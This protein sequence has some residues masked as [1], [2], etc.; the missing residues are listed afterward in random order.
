MDDRLGSI[1]DCCKVSDRNRDC[2]DFAIDNS[3]VGDS[4]SRAMPK[5]ALCGS[6]DI[7]MI[8][9]GAGE[10]GIGGVVIV[11][12]TVISL[13]IPYN[14]KPRGPFVLYIYIGDTM[15]RGVYIPFSEQNRLAENS[16][17]RGVANCG[18]KEV[19]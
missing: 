17:L 7:S 8:S 3:I 1:G 18:L 2:W 16:D 10:E 11:S 4:R 15:G 5:G 6:G 14:P 12:T 9:V 19:R 13:Y